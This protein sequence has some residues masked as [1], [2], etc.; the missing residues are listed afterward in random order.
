MTAPGRR[1]ALLAG[2]FAIV[3]A[4]ALSAF[5]SS[6]ESSGPSASVPT[7]ARSES[8]TESATTIPVPPTDADGDADPRADGD[9]NAPESPADLP[10]SVVLYGDSVADE[11]KDYF[12]LALAARAPDTE[13]T[14]RTFPGTAVC[15]WLVWMI[16]DLDQGLADAAVL[17]FSGN[18][19]TPCMQRADGT[20]LS[21]DE[22]LDTYAADTERAVDVLVAGGADVYLGLAPP[23]RDEE[24][25]GVPEAL[26][27]IYRAVAAAH[28]GVRVIDAGQAVL[29]DGRYTDVL[30]CLDFEGLEHGCFNGLILVRRYVD[31]A[32][33][34]PGGHVD[35]GPFGHCPIWPSGS[36]RYGTALTEPFVAA[37]AV[38]PA[39]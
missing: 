36:F 25:D 24:P 28:A 26:R 17:V 33:F 6:S 7:S 32:H 13:V 29:D 23:S 16:A 12:R 20:P 39:G 30:P 3:I 1:I 37:A 38:E 34:C 31:G 18:A 19:F 11:A 35:E 2:I 4:I 27:Q 22:Y 21:R 5:G 10:R 14:I 9:E 15:D 8:E